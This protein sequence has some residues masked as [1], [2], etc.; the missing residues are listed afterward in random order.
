MIVGIGV[1]IVKVSR[2][3]GKVG[4][5]FDTPFA[6]KAYTE[7]EMAYARARGKGAYRSLAGFFGA[8]EAFFKATQ[9]W[10]GWRDIRVEHR[11]S[12][13]PHFEFSDEATAK[14]THAQLDPAFHTFHLTI[15]HE[16]EFAVVVVVV[17][18]MD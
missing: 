18:E 8:K 15:T 4:K 3:E 11:E 7:S 1:D 2:V 6:K 12:G 10:P 16:K 13:Q 5:D 9:V 14:L 17:E